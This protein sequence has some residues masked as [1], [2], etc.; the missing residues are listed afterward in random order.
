MDQRF[1]E[2]NAALLQLTHRQRDGLL[3]LREFRQQRR[4]L[5][6]TLIDPPA[7]SVI[8]EA[9]PRQATVASWRPSA[10]LITILLL[11]ALLVMILLGS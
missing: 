11:A 6:A 1:A 9:I 4:Q 3:N 8:V 2:F 7:P 10:L 5:L